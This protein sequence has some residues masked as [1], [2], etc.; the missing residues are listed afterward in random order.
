MC[1]DFIRVYERAFSP[2]YCQYLIDY[3]EWNKE[4]TKTY[5][6]HE[7]TKNYKEDESVGLGLNNH[8]RTFTKGNMPY[9]DH[10]NQVFWEELYPQYVNEFP[11]L[12]ET[13]R[14]T[15]NCFKIQKTLP[16]QGYHIWHHEHS[17][18]NSN[19]IGTYI[20]YLND[21]LEGGETEFLHQSRRVKPTQGT[22]VI[23]PA[24]YTHMHRGNPPLSG[25]KYIMTGWIEYC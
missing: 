3:F 19:R 5:G 1:E 6:R 10:F 7:T 4:N 21:V 2:D 23:W 25:E 8:D 14:H 22:V 9:V 11:Q 20:V 15:I 18:H 16:G 24:A 12:Q 17:A 13:N